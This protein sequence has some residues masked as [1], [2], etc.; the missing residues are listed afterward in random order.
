MQTFPAANQGC[1]SGGLPEK[2][3]FLCASQR[4]PDNTSILISWGVRIYPQICR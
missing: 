2:I 3:A 4:A 1:N